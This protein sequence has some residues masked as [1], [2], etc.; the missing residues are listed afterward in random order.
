[1]TGVVSVRYASV[2]MM[3]VCGNHFHYCASS[4]L[5]TQLRRHKCNSRRYVSEAAPHF[6]T[7]MCTN[8]V[9]FG[10]NLPI[11][12][13]SLPICGIAVLHTHFGKMFQMLASFFFDTYRKQSALLCMCLHVYPLLHNLLR[14]QLKSGL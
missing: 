10:R 8:T 7:C 13:R 11:L 1:M 5:Q 14:T 9:L 12:R 3:H 6:G 4:P 2:K